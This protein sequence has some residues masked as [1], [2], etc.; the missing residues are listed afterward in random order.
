MKIKLFTHTDLDG[1]GCAV[2]ASVVFGDLIDVEYCS[3]DNVNLKVS[4]FLESTE[5]ETFDII[6]ITDISVNK[7]VADELNSC[8]KRVYLL[9]HHS[10]LEWLN[11]YE[12]AFVAIEY[13][14]RLQSGCNLF[15][16]KLLAI[17]LMPAV[18]LGA[19]AQFVEAVR[20]YD[21]YDW[22]RLPDSQMSK[23]LLDILGVIGRD[24]FVECYVEQIRLMASNRLDFRMPQEHALLLVYFRRKNEAYIESKLNETKIIIDEFGNRCA[25]VVSSDIAVISEIGNAMCNQFE[26]DYAAVY[27][28]TGISLRSV[29]SFDVSHIAEAYGGGGRCNTAGMPAALEYLEKYIGVV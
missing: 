5:S 21:T 24:E 6:F 8:D 18:D 9:D 2:V 3:Y 1:V 12:W 4:E 29:G 20:R 28:G 14:G 26:C 13:D 7:Q 11:D 17:D 10:N 23:D 22:T 25:F 15:Y 19:L 16:D 27:H